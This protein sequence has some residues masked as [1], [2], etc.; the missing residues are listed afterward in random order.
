[1]MNVRI[2]KNEVGSSS[3]G[4]NPSHELREYWPFSCH[5]CKGFWKG[6]FHKVF[7]L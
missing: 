1:M 7:V 6:G 5:S 3:L 2:V 4:K